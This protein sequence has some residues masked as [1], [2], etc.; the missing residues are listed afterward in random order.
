MADDGILPGRACGNCTMCCKLLRIEE[1]DK[2]VGEWCRHC[3]IGKGCRIY[4]S[5]PEPCRGFNCGYLTLPMVGE[6]WFPA[7]SRMIVY[8]APDGKRISIVVDQARALVWRE[9]PYFSE[10]IAWA[11]HGATRGIDVVVLAG[12]RG[13]AVTPHGVVDKGPVRV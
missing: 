9:E 5:R 1:L 4:D 11:R 12:G 3:D 7:K 13:Y 10:I 8:P 2:P 6:H